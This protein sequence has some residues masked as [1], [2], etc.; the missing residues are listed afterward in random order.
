MQVLQ[1]Y[2][3]SLYGSVSRHKNTN[4]FNIPRKASKFT[5]YSKQMPMRLKNTNNLP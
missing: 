2:R 4:F 5:N 3:L 1:G